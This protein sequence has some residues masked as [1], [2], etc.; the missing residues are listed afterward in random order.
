MK[1]KILIVLPL[2]LTVGILLGHLMQV[3]ASAPSPVGHTASQTGGSTIDELTFNSPYE[4]FFRGFLSINSNLNRYAKLTFNSKN[5]ANQGGASWAMYAD[6]DNSVIGNRKWALW[7]YPKKT[8]DGN[9]Y[10]Y[11]PFITAEF[12]TADDVSYTKRITLSAD[13]TVTGNLDVRQQLK[14]GEIDAVNEGGE[15]YW[16]GGGSNQDF[17]MDRYTNK[18]RIYLNPSGA[19]LMNIDSSGN[20]NV[21]GNLIGEQGY[22]YAIFTR[23]VGTD[24]VWK[25]VKM[26]KYS[27]ID[28]TN[29]NAG[30]YTDQ[31][32]MNIM[33]YIKPKYSET[34][35]FYVTTDDGA[36]LWIGGA[37]VV[38]SWQ[39]QGATTYTG[40]ISLIGNKWYP[41]LL[42]HYQE[43]S[44]ERLKLEWSSPSQARELI[45]GNS[46]A[47]PPIWGWKIY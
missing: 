27:S 22:L 15:I 40:T 12:P 33:G 28:W 32:T 10:G 41:I 47:M 1:V 37:K 8:S 44:S 35:T 42:E 24:N 11:E 21:G 25:A 45:S 19:E 16:E 46:F 26:D 5:S 34:Y 3:L 38:E 29:I 4:Y 43:I 17:I 6:A 20:L 18:L 36:A 23:A 14:L 13:T 39:S 7:G 31:L 30:G 9:V 2:I